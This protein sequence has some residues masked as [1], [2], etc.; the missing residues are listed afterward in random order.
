MRAWIMVV[1]MAAACG[2]KAPPP[3]KP[4]DKPDEC[5]AANTVAVEHGVEIEK[6]ENSDLFK[7]MSDA[8][9]DCARR[10]VR[11]KAP[12]AADAPECLKNGRTLTAW[13]AALAADTGEL[14][15]DAA[16]TAFTGEIGAVP[17]AQRASY[18]LE[19]LDRA[20]DCGTGQLSV[21]EDLWSYLAETESSI[22]ACK[23]TI[24]VARLELLAWYFHGGGGDW[25][26]TVAERHG[27]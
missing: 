15:D 22:D 11:S 24:D 17:E 18:L 3:A 27:P 7:T 8:D 9:I 20:Y 25:A 23:C 4:V 6:N 21:D 12:L 13:M 2:G 26:A 1:V 16:R 14:P 10:A 5:T 19:A